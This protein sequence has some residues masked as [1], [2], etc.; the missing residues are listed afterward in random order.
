MRY[1]TV[2]A[3][4]FNEAIHSLLKMHNSFWMKESICHLA[5]LG[6]LYI[7]HVY[8]QLPDSIIFFKVLACSFGEIPQF[9][10]KIWKITESI[11]AYL[12]FMFLS[13][14][15]VLPHRLVSVN[16]ILFI[17]QNI[18]RLCKLKQSIYQLYISWNTQHLLE[19]TICIKN[20]YDG[21]L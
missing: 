10:Q 13:M 8:I 14:R 19:I 21:K 12:W 11:F 5:P 9:Q 18:K 7:A 20:L 6:F 3:T 17:I 15:S 4:I 2:K 16:F 1:F